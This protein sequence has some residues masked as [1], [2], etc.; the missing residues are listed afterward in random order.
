MSEETKVQR[1]W[2]L[3]RR[4]SGGIR[5][6]SVS[7]A[8][9]IREPR[10]PPL[11]SDHHRSYFCFLWVWLMPLGGC[12]FGLSYPFKH[13]LDCSHSLCVDS[14][15]Q[16]GPLFCYFGA[17]FLDWITLLLSF[18]ETE[19]DKEWFKFVIGQLT[20][21]LASYICVMAER[22]WL[23]THIA[24]VQILWPWE[25]PSNPLNLSFLICKMGS[26]YLPRLWG[27]MSKEGVYVQYIS[28]CVY[29]VFLF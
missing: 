17:A 19:A 3:P 21:K 8:A 4:V 24:L 11:I 10:C 2:L 28:S 12:G 25:S 23:W 15:P 22:G 6:I 7:D 9:V 14:H 16:W 5:I 26:I 18:G 13:T 1:G 20:A 27:I 29:M